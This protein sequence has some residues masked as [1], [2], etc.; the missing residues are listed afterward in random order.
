MADLVFHDV[1][2]QIGNCKGTAETT[3]DGRVMV[4]VTFEPG[5]GA[6]AGLSSGTD[7]VLVLDAS[8]SMFVGAYRNGR[9]LDFV[10]GMIKFMNPYDDDGIDVYLHSLKAV[11]FLH[12]GAHSEG[13]TVTPHFG[14]YMEAG[15]ASKLMGQ[16]TICAPVI[17][18]IVN[19]LKVEKGS[20]RVFIEVVTDGEFNDE[21]E[22]EAAIIL[23]GNRYNSKEEPFGI[24]FHFTGVGREGSKG[25]Q[26]LDSLDN[27]L[28]EKYPGF[29]DCVQHNRAD[30]VQGNIEMILD[31]LRQSV[32]LNAENPYLE[33]AGGAG[34]P[35]MICDGYTNEWNDGGMVTWE[36]GLPVTVSL[37]VVFPTMPPEL[38]FSL[39]YG[40]GDSGETVALA[41]RATVG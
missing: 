3:P 20:N 13:D 39:N 22:V 11:P 9:V 40:D 27:E 41:F 25:L 23:Y 19:R 29:I 33:V 24:R 28:A 6:E 21:R 17:H 36:G 18:D 15:S 5:G 26:F 7:V 30:S 2:P 12:L 38:T 10:D 16:R 34:G 1:P 37:H 4:S 31:E 8:F 14:H 35:Q 32:R